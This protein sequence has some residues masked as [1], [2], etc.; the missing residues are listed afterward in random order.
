[1]PFDPSNSGATALGTMYAFACTTALNYEINTRL[2]STSYA[3]RMTAD[4]GD[5]DHVYEVGTSLQVLPSTTTGF[6][7]TS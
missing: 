7:P 1:L 2:E 4:G 6:F 5:A 3:S